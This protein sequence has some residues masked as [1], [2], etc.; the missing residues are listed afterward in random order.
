MQELNSS[1]WTPDHPA[2]SEA[3]AR[4]R[5]SCTESV[6]ASRGRIPAVPG[7]RQSSGV[8][9][10]SACFSRSNSRYSRS[11]CSEAGSRLS[12]PRTCTIRVSAIIVKD[13]HAYDP[14][15]TT[16]DRDPAVR[17][18]ATPCGAGWRRH[19]TAEV[20]C[21]AGSREPR[22]LPGS[23]SYS[24]ALIQRGARGA[25]GSPGPR[26]LPHTSHRRLV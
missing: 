26:K 3:G 18:S 4:A 23:V 1:S 19:D 6:F 7:A 10:S 13:E 17:V 8:F 9:P 2:D 15:R 5:V 25:P 24:P 14:D 21:G 12:R 16:A 11:H 22:L 20:A